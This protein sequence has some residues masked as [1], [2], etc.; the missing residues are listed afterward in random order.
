MDR[1]KLWNIICKFRR[2]ND[3]NVSNGWWQPL[4]RPKA[5][6]GCDE[7]LNALIGMSCCLH[8]L[9]VIYIHQNVNNT[10]RRT[11]KSLTFQR[12][13]LPL[14]RGLGKL[15]NDVININSLTARAPIYRSVPTSNAIFDRKFAL[16]SIPTKYG[17]WNDLIISQSQAIFQLF[18]S[19][20]PLGRSLSLWKISM[21]GSVMA[22]NA[23]KCFILPKIGTNLSELD[24]RTFVRLV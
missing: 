7:T 17:Q 5:M 11:N 16:H 20:T 22:D 4:E 10:H 12:K 13:Q 8:V 2:A 21:C 19:N 14:H 9:Q 24:F 6:N 18:S 23:R 3:Q 1:S 15:L